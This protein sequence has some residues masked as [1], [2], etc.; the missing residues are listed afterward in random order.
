MAPGTMP[1]TPAAPRMRSLPAPFEGRL[2]EMSSWYQNRNNTGRAAFTFGPLLQRSK[3]ISRAPPEVAFA[4][5]DPIAFRRS[6]I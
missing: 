5:T 6:E 1:H 2:P 3:L 4:F